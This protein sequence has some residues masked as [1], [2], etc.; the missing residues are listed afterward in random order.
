M[1]NTRV[2][3]LLD[4]HWIDYDVL[5]H[6]DTYTAQRTAA[7]AHVPGRQMAKVVVAR[8]NGHGCVMAVLPACAHLD[9]AALGR[10]MGRHHL[11]LVPEDELRRLFPDC[12]VGAMP[13][14]GR[15][16]GLPTYADCCFRRDQP[17]AFAAGNHHETVRMPYGD[18]EWAARP[19][20]REFCRH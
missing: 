4:E 2:Q 13:P 7:A 5:T 14:F 11:R 15:L 3:R 16:Y 18:W 19:V 20:V 8:E 6:E 12:E 9:L 17:I 10:A 1:L